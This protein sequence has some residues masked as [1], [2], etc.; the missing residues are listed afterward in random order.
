MDSTDEE[1]V[2]MN[3]IDNVDFVIPGVQA[4]EKDISA[5]ENIFC[6]HQKKMKSFMPSHL[7]GRPKSFKSYLDGI[8][9]TSGSM[10]EE[11]LAIQKRSGKTM[12]RWKHDPFYFCRRQIS[13]V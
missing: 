8:F 10:K 12:S 3:N 11:R 2:D 6:R 5:Q 13:P 7:P 9:Q 1:V 4:C